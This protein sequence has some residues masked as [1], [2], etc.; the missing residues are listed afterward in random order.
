MR[1]TLFAAAIVLFASPALAVQPTPISFETI[2]T[3]DK[4]RITNTSPSARSCTSY[5]SAHRPTYAISFSHPG[6]I[7][8]GP[9]RRR[10]PVTTE[11]AG[12][13]LS[14]IAGPVG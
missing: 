13:N 1:T 5:S 3:L 2:V 11:P 6:K 9:V 14:L 10:G 4:F 7:C 12:S 8:S